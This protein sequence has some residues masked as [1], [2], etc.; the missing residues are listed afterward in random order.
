MLQP[1]HFN[2]KGSNP[3]LYFQVLLLSQQFEKAVHYLLVNEDF[4]IE[5]VHFAIALYHYG[6]LHQPDPKSKGYSFCTCQP[7]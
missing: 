3:L 1:A 7:S 6:L 5:G 2:P 4:R